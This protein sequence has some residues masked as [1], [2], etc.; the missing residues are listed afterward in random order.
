MNVEKIRAFMQG[1]GGM[2]NN[3]FDYS[4]SYFKELQLK[5]KQHFLFA[6]EICKQIAYVN[7]GCLRHYFINPK[8]EEHIIY[9]AFEDWWVGD[10]SS[11]FSHT[12]TVYN[13]QALED[14]ELLTISSAD[15]TRLCEE[16]PKFNELYN[17]KTRNAYTSYIDKLRNEKAESPEEKYLKLLEKSPLVLQ[18]I[19]LI[20]IA[21]YLGIKPES[22]S[23]LR[24][25]LAAK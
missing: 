6:G 22:L 17:A 20:Y 10:L 14:C 11:F 24:K 13:L 16:R 8:G 15:F 12:P 21:S 25:R 19:P 7:R 1:K 2:S 9:F 4:M 3:D 18:R 5:K 23:R